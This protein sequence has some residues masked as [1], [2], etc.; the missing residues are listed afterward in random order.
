VTDVRRIIAEHRRAVWLI[1][2]AL[3]LNAALLALVVLPLAQKVRGGEEAAQAATAELLAARRDHAVATATVTGKSQADA[4][5]KK[6]Y[7]DVLPHDYSGARRMLYLNIDQL[8][9]KLN[10]QFERSGF[11]VDTE[12]RSD[13]QKLT[14]TLNLAGE[15][16]NIR[17][18]IHELETAPEFRVVESVALAQ[19]EEGERSLKVTASVATYYRTGGNGN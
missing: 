5:L 16:T 13:L 7:Q 15:Y 4:E 6:F 11:E 19:D 8:A 14:M 12:R 2:G 17:R 3:I 9:R 18:F 1:A 10:L